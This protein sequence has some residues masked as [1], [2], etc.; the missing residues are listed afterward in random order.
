MKSVDGWHW[1]VHGVDPLAED[2]VSFVIR[3]MVFPVTRLVGCRITAA[4]VSKKFTSAL[5]ALICF[6]HI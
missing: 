2:V 1:N 5:F 3:V 6:V 4:L